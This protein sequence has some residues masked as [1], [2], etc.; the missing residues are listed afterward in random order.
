MCW[1]TTPTVYTH[2]PLTPFRLSSSHPVLPKV[3][4]AESGRGY[5]RERTVLV[6][7]PSN[8][9]KTTCETRISWSLNN[10]EIGKDSHNAKL[11]VVGRPRTTPTIW[12]DRRYNMIQ[13]DTTRYSMPCKY[14]SGKSQTMVN[15]P[16]ECL[17]S[18]RYGQNW[19]RVPYVR[20]S[21]RTT[22]PV[23]V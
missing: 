23:E 4:K 18:L 14:D 12:Y 1:T 13:H 3:Q 10:I 15:S 21:P 9:F 8:N 2:A 17:V 6:G 22:E 11:W 19:F 16:R 5:W 7:K 20:A